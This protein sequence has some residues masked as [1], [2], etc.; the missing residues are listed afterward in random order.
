MNSYHW[1]S[2]RLTDCAVS[3]RLKNALTLQLGDGVTLGDLA[4][5]SDYQLTRAPN[6]GGHS[7]TEVRA[8]IA[9]V[10]H[11]EVMRWAAENM[12]IVKG[13]MRGELKVVPARTEL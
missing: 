8:Y 12:T 4:K 7:L 6:L 5:M 1:R 9:G 2:T 10:Q 13:L 11:A 3:A